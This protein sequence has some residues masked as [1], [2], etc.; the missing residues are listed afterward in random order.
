MNT[1]LPSDLKPA[2]PVTPKQ[3]PKQ[4]PKSSRGRWVGWVILLAAAAAAYHYWPQ[5]KQFTAAPAPAAGGGKG[6]GKGGGVTPVVAARVRKGDINLYDTGLGAVTP[7]YT[8]TVKSRVDGQLMKVN[9]KEGQLVHQ[10]ESLIEIDPRPY[11]AALDQAEGQLVHDQALLKNAH[12]DLDRYTVLLKQEAIPEQTYAT[13]QALVTQY[14]GNI[15]MDQAAIE[16][17]KVNLVYCHIGAPITGVVGLRLVDP[18]NIVHATDTNGMVVI[19]QVD[20]ISVIFTIPEDQL[21]AVLEKFHAGQTLAVEAWDRDLKTK[22]AQGT[23]AT[24]DNQIDPTTGTLRLRADF[25]NKSN[26][27]FPSQFVN[28]RLLVQR[29]HNVTLVDDAA[30]QRNSQNTYVWLIKPDNTV[31]IRQV[32]TGASESGL[33]EI[34]SGL[35]AGD[36]TVM[37]GVDKLQEGSRVSAQVAGEKP[38]AGSGKGGKKGS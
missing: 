30:I 24:I 18:G 36:E 13:Q 35:D 34:V 21:P 3:A 37:V 9:F 33:T 25:D 26:K 7:I 19:T 11:Q 5:I 28:A 23:L 17:A 12:V 1:T 32:T 10:G 22:L 20:P 27:L 29:K 16:A 8:V 6:K 14:D 15:K 31:T 2:A 38:Q 4:P